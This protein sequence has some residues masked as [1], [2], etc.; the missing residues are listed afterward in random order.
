MK[1]DKSQVGR[2]LKGVRKYIEPESVPEISEDMKVYYLDDITVTFSEKEKSVFFGLSLDVLGRDF[3]ILPDLS[4][5]VAEDE[6]NGKD[7]AY[8]IE[9]DSLLEFIN[10]YLSI[11]ADLL[12]KLHA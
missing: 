7:D 5:L 8:V 4:V 10:G 1:A 6:E 3:H 9:D 12:E 11:R 2:I